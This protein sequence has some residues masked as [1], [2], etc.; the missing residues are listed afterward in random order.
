MEESELDPEGGLGA[1]PAAA[2]QGA[3]LGGGNGDLAAGS[4]KSVELGAVSDARPRG[5]TTPQKLQRTVSNSTDE[6]A[7]VLGSTATP[8]SV[9]AGQTPRGQ[10]PRS[11]GL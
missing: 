3:D 9:G 6:A 1:M 7:A 4:R 2:A 8:R 10:Q 11:Q 5:I